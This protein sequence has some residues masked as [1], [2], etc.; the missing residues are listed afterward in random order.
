MTKKTIA[1]V[2]LLFMFFSMFI[3]I[4]Q[5]KSNKYTQEKVRTE[6]NEIINVAS[7]AKYVKQDVEVKKEEKTPGIM[8]EWQGRSF[9]KGEYEILCRTVFCEAGNQNLATQTMVALTILNRVA[10]KKFPNSIKD[11]VYQK[12]ATASIYP[13][14]VTKLMTALVALE[15]TPDLTKTI[16]VYDDVVDDLWNTGAA[17]AWL[18]PGEQVTMEQLLN[19]LL[20]PSACDAA[21]VIAIE[22][23]GSVDGFVASFAP[24][25]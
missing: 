19:L 24:L 13:A 15:Q 22:V 5:E 16:T 14:S 3:P 12:N 6:H 18:K 7:C 10:S 1:T 4:R 20:I 2:V 8:C 11:V 23:S 25:D 17:T 9:Q 21:N